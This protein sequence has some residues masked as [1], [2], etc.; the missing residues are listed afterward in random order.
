M[1]HM[2]FESLPLRKKPKRFAS[3]FLCCYEGWENPVL[4]LLLRNC[5]TGAFRFHYAQAGASRQQNPFSRNTAPQQ[6]ALKGRCLFIEAFLE[7]SRNRGVP[8]RALH[9]I[10]AFLEKRFRKTDVTSYLYNVPIVTEGL[11]RERN[12]DKILSHV[13]ER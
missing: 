4:P 6:R 9:G 11:R 12:G 2:V 10:P 5:P 13:R 3:V 1:L 7:P 8:H